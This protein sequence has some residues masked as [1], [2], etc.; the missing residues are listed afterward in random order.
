MRLS[1]SK[2][3]NVMRNYGMSQFSYET[4]KS[5]YD[6]DPKLQEL[7]ANFNQDTIELADGSASDELDT[8]PKDGGSSVSTMAKRATD[9]G[10]KL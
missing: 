9:L 2:L 8:N 4:F 7:V 6:A 5:A 3:D 10:D 1:I